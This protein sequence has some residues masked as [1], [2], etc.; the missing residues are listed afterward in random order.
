MNASPARGRRRGLFAALLIAY[1]AVA[2]G[3]TATSRI[4]DARQ[5]LPTGLTRTLYDR[6]GSA[7]RVVSQQVSTDIDLAFIEENPGL[8]QRYFRVRWDGFW[9]RPTN[10][11]IDLYAGADDRVSVKLDDATV[12]ERDV[13]SLKVQR[14]ARIMLPEGAHHLEVTYEQDGADYMLYLGAGPAGGVPERIDPESLFSR[15][16]PVRRLHVNHN[17]LLLRRA[18]LGAWLLPPALVL[19]VVAFPAAVRASRRSAR[20]WWRRNLDGVRSV[21]SSDTGRVAEAAVHVRPLFGVATALVT[22]LFIGGVWRFH[23]P[24]TGFTPLVAF[25]EQFEGQSLP[26]LRQVPHEVVADSGYDGQFY[27]QLAL[28]PMLRSQDIR[29]ALDSLPYRSRRILMSWTAYLLGFGRPAWIIKV[30]A[31]QNVVCWLLLGWV[32]FIWIPPVNLRN[33]AAWCGCVLGFGALVSVRFALTDLPSTTLMALGLALAE[34][35]RPLLASGMT[36]LS[37]LARETSVLAVVGI[38][39]VRAWKKRGTLVTLLMLF[40]LMAPLLL[41]ML[42]MSSVLGPRAWSSANGSLVVPLSGIAEYVLRAHRDLQFDGWRSGA[43]PGLLV[44]FSTGIQAIYLV[45]RSDWNDA[46]WRVG[47]VNVILFA[48]LPYPVFD[49]SPG[50]FVRVLLPMTLAYNLLAARSRWFWPLFVAGNLSVVQG[51]QTIPF[52]PWG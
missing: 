19:F 9:Y 3:T 16:P 5:K 40:F 20:A 31:I 28:D 38:D 2:A 26:A 4:L 43:L 27:A 1:V 46:W 32:L 12:L 22:L 30:Y 35:E 42:Y 51:I 10:Q 45:W 23:D 29:V 48:V 13:Q 36:G 24:V 33:W 41:W 18:A 8:P 14:R 52:I 50:A 6:S 15:R 11:W 17:L 7:A 47:A 39:W 34:K 49:G 25:G 37:V 21:V 44:L